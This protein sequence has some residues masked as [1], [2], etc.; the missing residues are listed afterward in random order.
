MVSFALS[1]ALGAVAGIL[2]TPTQYTA[3][4]VGVPFGIYGFIAAIIG[5][6][7]SASGALAGGILLGAVQALAI[8]VFGAGYKN[9]VALSILLLVLLLFPSGIFGGRSAKH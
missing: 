8:V 3:F 5:G 7:G 4:N 9:V 1:A 2:V 6:F